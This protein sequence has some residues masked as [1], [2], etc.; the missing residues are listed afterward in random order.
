M[1]KVVLVTYVSLDG[2][3]ENP[4]WTVPYWNDELAARGT[5]CSRR[6]RSYSAG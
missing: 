2:V 4:S 5:S 1:S 6:T 3:V